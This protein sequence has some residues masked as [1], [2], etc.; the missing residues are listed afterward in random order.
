MRTV[1]LPM[2]TKIETGV[3]KYVIISCYVVVGNSFEQTLLY[4]KRI[5]LW[6][7]GVQCLIINNPFTMTSTNGI[8]CLLHFSGS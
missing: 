7:S 8:Y 2:D 1:V 6:V 5:I 3:S 4:D